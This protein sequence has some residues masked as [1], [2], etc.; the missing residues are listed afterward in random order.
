ML[1]RKAEGGI[2]L[3]NILCYLERTAERFPDRTALADDVTAYTYREMVQRAKR[4]GCSLGQLGICRRPVAVY[5]DKTPDCVAAFLGVVYSGNFYVVLDSFM[6]AERVNRIFETLQPA[7]VVTDQTHREQAERFHFDGPCVIYEAAQEEPISEEFLQSVR[8]GMVET[9]P[10]YALYT[11]GSTG[12]PKGAVVSHRA[13]IAYSAWVIETF[14]IDENTVFGSQTPFYFSMSVTDLYST[15][16]TG[17]RLQ[18]IPKTMFSFPLMLM[19]YMNEYAVNTIYWVPSALCIVANWDTFAYAKPK[20]L[21][22]ILFAGEVMPNKQLNYWRRHLPEAFYANLFGPTETTDICTYYVVNRAFADDEALPIGNACDNCDTFIVDENGNCAEHGELYVRG[23]F[24]ADGYYNAPDKTREA[25]VQNPLNH[26]YPEIVYR[27]GD[28]VARNAYGELIYL[29]R[30]D[31]QIKHMG[32]R[33][34]LGEIE[35]GAGAAEGVNACVCVYDVAEDRIVLLYQ[36]KA[37]PAALQEQVRRRLP[38]YM[39]PDQTIRLKSM[40]YNANGKIDRTYIKN[41]YH[42]M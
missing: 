29:G 19:E 28:L 3:K 18:I 17:A 21:Q 1:R 4:V 5:M 20:Q 36:G 39:H 8:R 15:L 12:Q 34:E 13:V 27:T 11:S 10:L 33:I 37:K 22:K 41:H 40:P 30:R 16:R 23:P 7:A 35:A 31:L 24:L 14:G 38:V 42:E 2:Q 6:P 26:A 32:Y 9:D 25:F